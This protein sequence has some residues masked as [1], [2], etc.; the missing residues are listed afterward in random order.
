MTHGSSALTHVWPDDH[1]LEKI[2]HLCIPF[3]VVG[4]PL[5]AVMA[6][7]PSGPYHVMGGMTMLTLAA[8]F[9]RPVYRTL[10]F[11]AAGAV[12]FGYYYWI[13]NV[14][15]VAQV[16]LYVAGAVFF[17]RNGGHSRPMGLQDHHMLHYCVT[18]ASLLHVAYIV[19]AVT[20]GSKV[21]G[22]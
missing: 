21:K 7:R 16:T 17:V 14:N 19:R 10:S 11:V 13:I 4:T 12:M 6:L 8:A 15:L 1:I 3:L 18:A 22:A 2:D 20:L 5:T 9:L